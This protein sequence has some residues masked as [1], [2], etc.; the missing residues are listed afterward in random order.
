MDDSTEVAEDAKAELILTGTDA[1]EPLAAAVSSLQRY[2][3]LSAIEVFEHLDSPVAGP[4]LIELLD[5]DHETV[6]EWS[7]YALAQLE[8]RDAVPALQ[9][10]YRRQ[11]ASG[12]TPDFS[13]AVGIRYALAALGAR[14]V[15]VPPLAAS[16]AASAPGLGQAWPVA[17]LEDVIN[18]LADHRQACCIFS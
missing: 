15:V 4:V 16:W 10:A 9:A 8:V 17:R 12:T 6:R 3:Q 18:E 5:S 1:A 7:A 13:E 11:R 2:G 14:R